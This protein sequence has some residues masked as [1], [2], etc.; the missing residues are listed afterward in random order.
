MTLQ[1][2]RWR[3]F[4]RLFLDC[5]RR[6]PD[7]YYILRYEDL[8]TD[9]ESTFRSL[10]EFLGIAYD[11]SVFNFHKKKEETLNTYG[12]VIWEK[13]HENLL[14]P[15]N[16]GRM[17]T[18]KNDLSAE[19]VKMADQIAGKY[20]DQLGYERQNKGFNF[21]LYLKS[22]PMMAYNYILFKLMILGTY[23]PYAV[24][25][26]WFFKSLILLRIYMRLVGKKSI[27]RG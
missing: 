16:T 5:K 6:Y 21:W 13:F 27:S 23:M 3:Y 11:P 10:C 9:Q 15:I 8:V 12:N 2:A 14:K 22:R 25:R 4:V 26:W 18:W 24:S 1:V 20:A 17:N 19:Q 7:K